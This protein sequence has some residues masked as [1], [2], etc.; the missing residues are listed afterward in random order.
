MSQR[1]GYEFI[2]IYVLMHN[3]FDN[4]ELLVV[5]SIKQQGELLLW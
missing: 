4:I 5:E 2:L 3:R 1:P